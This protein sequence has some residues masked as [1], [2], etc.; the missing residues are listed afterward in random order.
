[1]SGEV[2]EMVMQ[3]RVDNLEAL[4]EQVEGRVNCPRTAV[5]I[6]ALFWWFLLLLHSAR[7][8]ESLRVNPSAVTSCSRPC[9]AY[10]FLCLLV[11]KRAVVCDELAQREEGIDLGH[12]VEKHAG[13][14]VQSLYIADAFAL[15][16]TH[17]TP[18]DDD[19]SFAG[20][21]TQAD[22]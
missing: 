13:H 12:H 20:A 4:V 16:K 11:V 17:V 15:C 2:F 3:T 9:V 5:V 21:P 22:N 7:D 6:V 19:G 10:A 1:M 8:K 14:Y 18:D